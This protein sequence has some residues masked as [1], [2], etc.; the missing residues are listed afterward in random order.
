MTCTM[1]ILYFVAAGGHA[2]MSVPY[3][4]AL[5]LHS[6]M[7]M[8]PSPAPHMSSAMVP[9]HA[10]HHPQFS[11]GHPG[12]GPPTSMYS[13]HGPYGAMTAPQDMPPSSMGKCTLTYLFCA[14]FFYR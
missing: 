13:P 2:C 8:H 10:H 3:T 11:G 12:M 6:G 4:S 7:T 1:F 5:G 9:T 14:Y